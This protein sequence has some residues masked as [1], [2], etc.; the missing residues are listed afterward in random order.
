M[1]VTKI[2][3]KCDLYYYETEAFQATTPEELHALKGINKIQGTIPGNVEK[4]LMAAGILPDIYVGANIKEAEPLEINEWWYEKE[5]TVDKDFNDYDMVLRFDGVDTVATYFINGVEIGKSDNML[6]EHEFNVNEYLVAGKNT[7][8]VR[9]E[10]SLYYAAR[11]E[12]FAYMTGFPRNFEGLSIRKAAHMYGWDITPRLVSA[13]IWKGVSLLY[14][15][16]ARV[17]DLYLSTINVRV[18]EHGKTLAWIWAQYNVNVSP[19]HFNKYRVQ[20]IG[21]CGDSTFE[22]SQP[23]RFTHSTMRT[24]VVNAKLWWPHGY[25]DPNLYDITFN[26]FDEEGNLVCDYHTK[27]GLRKCKLIRTDVGVGKDGEFRVEVNNVPIMCKG[28]NWVPLDS[29]HSNDAERLHKALDLCVDSECNII[30]CWGGNV[31]ESDEFFNLCDQ[32]GILVWQDFG[33]ACNTYPQGEDFLNKVKEEVKKFVLRVRNHPCLALY[34]GNNEIDWAWYQ[35]F[36]DPEKMDDLC[37]RVIP[38]QLKLYDPFRDYYPSSPYYAKE[39]CEKRDGSIMPE[40][41]AWGSRDYYKGEEYKLNLAHFIGEFGYFGCP[42]ASS[43]KKFI[44]PENL[45]PGSAQNEEWALHATDPEGP[46][47][48]WAG[49]ITQMYDQ[50]EGIFGHYPTDLDELAILSQGAQAEACKYML[51]RCRIRKP[52][53]MGIL[54]WNM[55]DCWPQFSDAVVDYYY[56]KKMA[57]YFIKQSQAPVTIAMDEPKSWNCGV[58][59][60]NDTNEMQNGEYE[61]FNATTGKVVASGTFSA[62][63]NQNVRVC[64]VRI[65][66]GDKAV[67][68]LRVVANGVEHKNHYLF[69]YP[70]FSVEFYMEYLKTISEFY[71]IDLVNVAK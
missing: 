58:H 41:H 64:N 23:L 62:Q 14:K 65:S 26:V 15:G 11:Q 21:K 39:V 38:A 60:L 44:S 20:L 56:T 55:I 19:K 61:V 45:W 50:L 63:P 59:I 70:A 46:G 43:V 17:E 5:F 68:L 31:Y 13:G 53:C 30:R 4:D 9:I 36:M 6:V 48:W 28:T 22:I 67:Y 7:L 27:F 3:G 47:G 51:E 66:H 16:K 8:S 57:Y 37:R 52:E 25:G 18:D 1:K 49:R 32:H 33:F 2:E 24:D 42:A 35:F 34:C 69:G 40:S 10:S 54:W 29:M 12:H 71:G